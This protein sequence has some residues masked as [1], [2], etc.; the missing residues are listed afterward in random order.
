MAVDRSG[1]LKNDITE[2]EYRTNKLYDTCAYC[3]FFARMIEDGRFC[4]W[5]CR[6]NNNK[7]QG[8][9]V[10]LNRLCSVCCKRYKHDNPNYKTCSSK[11]YNKSKKLDKKIKRQ[12]QQNK[13]N[14]LR[15]KG[16][17]K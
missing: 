3:G 16:I 1:R 15:K 9:E 7:A 14:Y 17:I 10:E 5:A 11:C 12:A 2:E 6:D 8:K 13:L 4:S